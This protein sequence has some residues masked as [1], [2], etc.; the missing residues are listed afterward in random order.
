MRIWDSVTLQTLRILGTRDASFEKGI[1]CVAFSRTDGGTLLAAI[2]DSFEHTLS[3]WD[4]QRSKRLTETK[5]IS[6]HRFYFLH[7]S[8]YIAT[9]VVGSFIYLQNRFLR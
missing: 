1:S 6:Y 4:W 7:V 5:V 9:T 2:D 8:T 3:V